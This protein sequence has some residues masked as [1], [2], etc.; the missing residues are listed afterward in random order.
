MRHARLERSYRGISERLAIRYL[1]KL[2]GERI[3]EHVVE[4]AGGDGDEAG[5]HDWRATLTAETVS[6]GP[7]M[8][9]TEVTVLLEGEEETV[10][11]L[12]ERFSQKAMRAGG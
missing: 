1:E 9:L 7:T 8:K 3:E 10:E 5:G 2:G 12:L 4:S 6:I 11:A